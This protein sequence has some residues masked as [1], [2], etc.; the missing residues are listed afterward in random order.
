MALLQLSSISLHIHTNK[1]FLILCLTSLNLSII[2]AQNSTKTNKVIDN[3]TPSKSIYFDW[4]NRNWYG[5]NEK[6]VEANLKFFKW[7][8]DEY[9]MQLDIYLMDAADIDQGPNCAKDPGLPAYGS[10]ETAWFKSRFPHGF[11]PL[12][13]LAKSFNCRLGIWLGPDGYGKTVEEAQRKN[14][15]T[16]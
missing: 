9:G 6:K 15:R 2:V 3:F 1:C 8:H 11:G 12:V 13:E 16:S 7:L 5:S 10:L 4:I 14:Q